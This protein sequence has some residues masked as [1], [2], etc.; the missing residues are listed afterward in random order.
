MH[1]ETVFIGFGSNVGDRHELCD[2]AVTLMG[3]MPHSRVC[4]VSS[5]YETRPI[6]PQGVLGDTWFYN[7]VVKL[8]TTLEIRKLFEICQ[9]TEKALGRDEDHRS[10]PRT[11]D[12]D[13]LFYG[14]QIIH[15][16]DL[17]VPHPRLH[18]RRFVLEPFIEIDPQWQH[19][20]YNRSVTAIYHELE[21]SHEVRKLDVVPGTRF[22]NR[23]T[24]APPPSE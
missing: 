11:M 17:T 3:L 13:I 1:P 4:G 16:P 24:C 18:L 23:P 15:E 22:G 2:R 10:G 21:D 7:G 9:E 8:E 19:P 14:Q 20:V 6:D 5:Y 12:F